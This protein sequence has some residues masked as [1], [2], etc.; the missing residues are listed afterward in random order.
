VTTGRTYRSSAGASFTCWPGEDHPR[1]V[2][3]W[4]FTWFS[5]QH[6][7]RCG[8]VAVRRGCRQ[9]RSLPAPVALARLVDSLTPPGAKAYVYQPK[10][11]GYRALYAAGRL[12][13]RNGTNLTPLF[14]DL[15]PTLAARLTPDPPEETSRSRQPERHRI[16]GDR[17]APCREARTIFRS[18]RSSIQDSQACP[19]SPRRH[20][21]DRSPSSGRERA[22]RPGSSLHSHRWG[23]AACCWGR[24]QTRA[25]EVAQPRVFEVPPVQDRAG[26]TCSA[27][28]S[29]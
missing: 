1:V 11:D 23:L 20:M 29:R 16:R 13:S 15:I 18:S 19:P 28:I 9:R 3:P 6:T 4:T 22:T 25:R 12:Y 14:P 10:W 7:R 26:G 5:S 17:H 2:E 8:R 24:P 27:G 21:L